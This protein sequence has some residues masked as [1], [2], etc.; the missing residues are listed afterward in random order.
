MRANNVV[1]LR[2]CKN[3]KIHGS[4]CNGNTGQAWSPA[5][6]IESI[7][8]GLHTENIEIYEN[9]IHDT[10]G[11]GIWLACS[12]SGSTGI[13]IHNNLILRCGQMPADNNIPGVGGIVFD[14]FS[15]VSITNNTIVDSYGYGILAGNYLL[16]SNV[17][18][19]ATISNNII[20]GTHKSFTQGLYSGTA[21]ANHTSTRNKLECSH[22]CLWGNVQDLYA[23][24]QT[25][26][27][28]KDPLFTSDYNLLADSPCKG[29]GCYSVDSSSKLLISCNEGDIKTVTNV[30]PENYKVY[31]RER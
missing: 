2:D 22:N 28:Y 15:N 9:Y 21:I 14:G 30:L 3:T 5:I 29:L 7:T 19:S 8:S 6:Q 4:E 1:R 20:T 11:P 18:G 10:Y 16:D 17:S 13:N 24:T 12:V 27:I 25:S 23:V 26:G 31:K